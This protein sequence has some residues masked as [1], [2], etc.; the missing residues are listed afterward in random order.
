ME[1]IFNIKRASDLCRRQLFLNKNA[2]L[3]SGGAV[4]GLLLCITALTGHYHPENLHGLNALNLV[5]MFLGG[6]V[7]SS[8]AFSELQN[9]EKAMSYLTLPVSNAERF[10]SAWV[11]TSPFYIIGSLIAIVLINSFGVLFASGLNYATYME[12]LFNHNFWITIAAYL[13]AQPI[14]FLGAVAFRKNNLMKT[15]LSVFILQFGLIAFGVFIMWIS[16][17]CNWQYAKEFNVDPLTFSPSIEHLFIVISKIVYW[18][19]LPIY[20][21]IVSFFKLKERQ[22]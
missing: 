16:F 9:T 13:S 19:V 11:L 4:L 18:G 5:V 6:A 2:L 8:H 1:D 15:L 20:L 10:F 17:G 22:L 14:F 12:H 3:I 21:L 7:F